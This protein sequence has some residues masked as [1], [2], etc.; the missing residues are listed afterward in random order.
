MNALDFT[1]LIVSMLGIAGYGIWRTRDRRNLNTYLKGTGNTP[2]YA[3]GLSVM[4]TQASAI[5]FLSTPGQGYAG[6]LGFVQ[7]YFG[8]PLALIIISIFFLPVFRKLNVYTAYEFLGRRFDRK[9]RLLGAGLFL[10]QRGLGAGLTIYM[11]AIVLTSMFG[12]PLN[13]TIA[14]TGLLVVIYTA[15][16]GNDA[17]TVT[18][19]YQLGIIFAGMV[20]AF[21]LLV[22]KMPAGLSFNDSLALAAGFHKL[23]AVSFSPDIH[24]RYTIWSGILGGTFLM[25]SYFGTDQSQVQRYISNAPIRE[26]RL[27]LMMNALCKIPMQFSILLLGVLVFVFYQFEQPPL[28]FNEASRQYLASH[29]APGQLA[30]WESD[31]DAAHAASRT[32]L[33]QWLAARHAG[34][35][36]AAKTAMAAAVTAQEQGEIIRTKAAGEAQKA[37]PGTTTNDADYIFIT[38]ILDY[39]PHGVI[40]LLVAAFFAATLSSKAAELNALGSSTTIDVYRLLKPEA[41][42]AQCLRASRWFTA[43]WGLLAILVA[44]YAHLGENLIQA[45][46]KLGSIFYGVMLALFVIAFFLRGI[47]GTAVF[48]GAVAAQLLVFVSYRYLTISYLWFP[49]MG[50]AA[51]VVFSLVLQAVGRFSGTTGG[52]N[53]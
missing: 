39:L 25:L 24:E 27:G 29:S 46:N 32:Q 23:N 19:K 1:V 13:L 43:L 51:C 17:V 49:L 8:V 38:F 7:I 28:L 11:P 50:C 20:T 30:S 36:A 18:Q 5:T 26:S 42:D 53:E 35:E 4:A 47:T 44:L 10:V 6:G 16:G 2:W 21:C 45:V 33:E 15:V 22:S 14:S 9:T 52:A 37:G 34:D 40:G 48:W 31:F 3:I 12:W 41:T